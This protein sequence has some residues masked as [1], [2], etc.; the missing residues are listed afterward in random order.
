MAGLR[1]SCDKYSKLW[2]ASSCRTELLQILDKKRPDEGWQIRE[3][4]FLASG[5]FSRDNAECQKRSMLQFVAFMDTV[6]HVQAT[7]KDHILLFA[8]ELIYTPVDISFLQ[9]FKVAVSTTAD[10]VD[11]PSADGP[12][13]SCLGP[14]TMI[15]ELYMDMNLPAMSQLL[16]SNSK[17]MVASPLDKRLSTALS[18]NIPT[19]L[20]TFNDCRG[21]YYLPRFQEDPSVF[22]GLKV[23]W[24]E[25]MD[26]D[27]P[28]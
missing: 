13:R 11:Q 19:L 23:Y 5:S 2:K 26:D 14:D 28:G 1:A 20:A 7:S 10:L 16:Y 25:P 8:E 15:F 12:L 22:E 3:A 4:V 17:L 6:K 18:H 24:K 9:S 27:E 21:S